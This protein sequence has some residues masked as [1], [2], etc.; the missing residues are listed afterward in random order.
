MITTEGKIFE[1]LRRLFA[2]LAYLLIVL[3][4]VGLVGYFEVRDTVW[5]MISG[6]IVFSVGGFCSDLIKGK[7]V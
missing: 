6:Y 5:L 3:I 1:F 4:G 7:L 2:L